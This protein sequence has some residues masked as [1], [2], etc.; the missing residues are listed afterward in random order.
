MI[1]H[2]RAGRKDIRFG[3][4]ISLSLSLLYAIIDYV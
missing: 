3:S 2:G 4:A 1:R